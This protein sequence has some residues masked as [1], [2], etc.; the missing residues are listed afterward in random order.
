MQDVNKMSGLPEKQVLTV[1]VEDYFH[2]S[3][4][5]KAINRDDWKNLELRVEANT[6]KL[7]ALFEQKQVKCTFF[8]LGW[9]AERC[10]NLIKAIVDQGHELASH[11]FAHQRATIMTPDEFRQD[12]SRS[13][14]VL[15]D[16]SGQSIIGYRAPS[17]SFNDS[18][19][20]VYD[21]LVELGFEYSSSTYP[22]EHD[23]YG[24]PDWPRFKYQRAEGIIEIPVPT[25]RKNEQNTGI[26][27]GGYFRLY[28]YWLSKRRIDS[29]LNAEKQPYS[30]YFH[31]WEIDPEQPRVAGASVKSKLRHYL[32]L[33]RMEGKIV[34]LLED[35]QWDTM[36]SVYLGK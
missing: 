14:A 31:P 15:E 17:F 5:E 12:V 35:Y 7:L 27:G 22:I 1:D 25:I 30:F 9:V 32:N 19:T 33:S 11:G 24:V 3:A 4:F 23:L 36:K 8:T 29:Y 34:R 6:Y 16:A 26:G 10:P 21:I 13:K 2:V 28:P 18:N 20:W